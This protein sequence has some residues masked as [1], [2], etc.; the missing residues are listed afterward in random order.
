MSCVP[1]TCNRAAQHLH[2][3]QSPAP[4]H[5]IACQAARHLNLKQCE[6]S[7]LVLTTL[8][9]KTGRVAAVPA[10][11]AEAPAQ[12]AANPTYEELCRVHV[13]AIMSAAAA[14][15]VQTELAARWVS[16]P[17]CMGPHTAWR[18]IFEVVQ[19]AAMALWKSAVPHGSTSK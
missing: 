8:F 17:G 7:T 9:S 1:S 2:A 13:D 18:V 15:D 11:D 12:A 16:G 4:P 10:W 6:D 14:A 3:P 5:P 19:A